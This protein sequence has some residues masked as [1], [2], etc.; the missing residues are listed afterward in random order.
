MNSFKLLT[1]RISAGVTAAALIG[2]LAVG[3]AAAAPTALTGEIQPFQVNAVTDAEVLPCVA[4]GPTAAD[5][6]L[7]ATLNPLLSTKMR[8]NMNSYNVSCARA[9]VGAVQGRGLN[10]RAAAVAIATTIV[11]SAIA[12][13]NYG[14]LDS[15]GL[16]QQRSAWGTA[17]ERT[18]PTAATN[19]FLGAMEIKYKNGSWNTAPIGDVAA[20][21]QNPQE[22]LRFRYGVE[23]NDA[24]IIANA[25]WRSS[26]A[27]LVRVEDNGSLTAW[28]NNGF[29][30]WAAPATIG[31]AG[32]TDVSRLRFADLDGDGRDDLVSIDSDGTLTAWRSTG[33]GGWAAPA[34]VGN[35]GAADVS[36]LRFADLD[37][38]GRADLVRVE[39]N[40]SLTAWHN[41]GFG[42]WAAPAAIGNADTT[43]ASRIQF[44]DLDGDGR[45]DMVRVEDNGSL[46]AW[47]ST[48]FGG[49][50]APAGAGNTGTTDASRVRLADLDGD[51]LADL[52]RVEDGGSLTA[53]RSTG[54]GSWTAPTAV[55]NGGTANATR[56][57]FAELG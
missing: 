2:S 46:T 13:V 56:I 37:G 31:N 33:F 27:D 4:G 53:W 17:A 35:A 36:R 38:D 24:V 3:T 1:A 10:A 48:G 23:A 14:H 30:S 50:A 42:S 28:H 45:A 7:A 20:D 44:G 57:M 49:W 16:F 54:F 11:E 47:R 39:D 41:N 9:V 21:V 6:A 51:G 52:V 34:G 15:L 32:T 55:G 18:E 12:N 19:M 5:G 22:D 26:R 43:D 29:G 8:N 25:L 40:G